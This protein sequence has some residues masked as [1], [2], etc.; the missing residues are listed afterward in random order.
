MIIEEQKRKL[1]GDETIK[2]CL[3]IAKLSKPKNKAELANQLV[4][5]SSAFQIFNKNVTYHLLLL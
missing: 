4:T 1:A 5:F 2:L 3:I